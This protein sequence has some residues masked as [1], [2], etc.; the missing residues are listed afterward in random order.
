MLYRRRWRWRPTL[1]AR[2]SVSRMWNSVAA[3]T[4]AFAANNSLLKTRRFPSRLFHTP[5]S[6]FVG[7]FWPKERRKENAIIF[8]SCREYWFHSFET[9][10]LGKEN[11]I[12]E[13]VPCVAAVGTAFCFFIMFFLAWMASRSIS[14]RLFGTQKRR[15]KNY[16]SIHFS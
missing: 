16:H 8:S 6:R 15:D 9:K 13:W 11:I 7:G 2:Q 4:T 14:L 3:A 10:S 5:V 1:A 12:K